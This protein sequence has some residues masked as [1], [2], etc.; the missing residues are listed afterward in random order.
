[1]RLLRDR[2]GGAAA[3]LALVLPGIA[4][5]I[6]NVADLGFYMYTRMQV[7]LAAQAAVAAVRETCNTDAKLPATQNCADMNSAVT[8]GLQSTSLGTGVTL[9]SG[10]PIE[11][12]YCA[13]AS[14]TLVQAG[15]LDAPSANCT[16]A[17]STS[18]ATPGT[19]FRV[20]ATR[21]FTSIFPGAS[22][23]AL[24]TSPIEREA[25]IRLE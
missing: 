7:D 15:T 25:W 11:L 8:G 3:E 24:L 14:G 9:E 20:R 5:V 13:D 2:S 22:V 21:T 10:Y 12:P 17:V 4:F 23:A 19:Y 6:A 18:T 1:M 16:A